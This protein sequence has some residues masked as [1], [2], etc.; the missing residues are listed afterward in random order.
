MTDRTVSRKAVA[1]PRDWLKTTVFTK[2]L[3]IWEYLQNPECRQLIASE[4]E[5]LAGNFLHWIEKTLL[6][7]ARLRALYPDRLHEVNIGWT[8]ANRWSG[9]ACD[10]PR[11]GIYSEPSISV[12]GITGAAQSGH[13]DIIHI[14]DLVGKATMES[15]VV[16]ESVY[17]WF[18]NVDELLVEPDITKSSPS[19]VDIVGCLPGDTRILLHDG[20]WKQIRSI[21]KGDIVLSWNNNQLEK[22][23]VIDKIP[24]KW[25]FVYEIKTGTKTVKAN[26]KHPFLMKSGEWKK[27]GELQVGDEIIVI[28]DKDI[29][30]K[31][32]SELEA[33]FIGLF[34]GDG[35][36]IWHNCSWAI[37]IADGIHENIREKT[38]LAYQKIVDRKPRLSS[39]GQWMSWNKKYGD[40]LYGLGLARKAKDKTIPEIILNLD[41][42]KKIS[43]IQG[44]LDADGHKLKRCKNSYRIELSNRKMIEQLESLCYVCGIKTG[45]AYHRVRDC[46]PKYSNGAIRS[47]TWSLNINMGT[48]NLETKKTEDFSVEKIVSIKKLCKRYV[49]DLVTKNNHTFIAEGFVVHNT[50]WSNGDLFCYI[51]DK[52]RE[53]EWRIVPALKDQDLL[54]TDHLKWVQ[55]PM[56]F[57]NESNWPEYKSTRYY[58]KMMASP[59]KDIIFWAQHM[60]NPQRA[61]GL[62]KFDKDWLRYYDIEERDKGKY[63]VCEDDKKEFRV[64]DIPLI[65]II[66][67][68]GFSEIKLIKKGSNNAILIGGQPRNSIKKFV[69]HIWAGKLKDPDDFLSKVFGANAE[70]KPR[71]WRIETIGAADYIYKHIM[72]EKKKRGIPMTI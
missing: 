62:N 4:N 17:R 29:K 44:L 35:S 60:N 58:N 71:T 40:F 56:S 45:K 13:Y 49:F 69:M 21:K 25:D 48:F 11:K 41:I 39:H 43:F 61:S 52:Y 63:I 1:M 30:N 9:E 3:T 22:D 66:D 47:E 16:M 23:Y 55:N 19:F 33:W 2:W 67:P 51:Q 12:I 15:P 57:H 68:G 10:L 42:H 28:Q 5:R 70:W 53:Y 24:Q 46:Y 18:D 27:A 37:C 72:L 20:T 65:G 54:D 59:E 14:D 34:L 64:N 32:I 26:F 38:L 31:S 7:N 50:H 8:K 36:L 6:S